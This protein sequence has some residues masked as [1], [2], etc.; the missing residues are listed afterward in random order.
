MNIDRNRQNNY[1]KTKTTFLNIIY[2]LIVA[3]NEEQNV[4]LNNHY[5]V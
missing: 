3:M 2:I 4:P 1:N 5:C